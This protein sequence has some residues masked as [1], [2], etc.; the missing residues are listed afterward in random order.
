MF[1]GRVV[2][3]PGGVLVPWV[4]GSVGAAVAVA[5]PVV[6]RAVTT[7]AIG[8]PTSPAVGIYDEAVAEAMFAHPVPE[9]LHRCH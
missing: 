8:E 5:G 7:T 3:P 4:S 1:A 2:V 9:A 6:F